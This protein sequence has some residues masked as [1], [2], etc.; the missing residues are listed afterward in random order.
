MLRIIG[1]GLAVLVIGWIGLL[2]IGI[3]IAIYCGYIGA[4]RD[5]MD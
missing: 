4:K 5:M 2:A 3:P 1:F